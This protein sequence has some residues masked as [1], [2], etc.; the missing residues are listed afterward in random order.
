MFMKQNTHNQL[1]IRVDGQLVTP[2]HVEALQT[3]FKSTTQQFTA[4]VRMQARMA[5]YDLTH[6]T[7]YRRIRNELVRQKRNREFEQSIGLVAIK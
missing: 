2:S 3:A 4:N 6:G 5:L 7:E 1:E